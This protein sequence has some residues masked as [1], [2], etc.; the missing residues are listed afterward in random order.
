MKNV[1]Q[2]KKSRNFYFFLLISAI[3][4]FGVIIIFYY[5]HTY[6][7]NDIEFVSNE[8]SS[9]KVIERIQKSVLDIQKMR[10]LAC[11]KSPNE[12]SLHRMESLKKEIVNDMDLLKSATVAMREEIPLR[13][14]LI[15]FISFVNSAQPEKLNFNEYTEIINSFM[16]FSNLV[17]YHCKLILEPD[18]DRY[19]LVNNIVS[20]FPELIEYNGQIRA[21]AVGASGSRITE[22]QKQHIVVQ[23]NKIQERMQKI[24]TNINLLGKTFDDSELMLIY[25][26]M[27]EAQANIE[28]FA[29]NELLSADELSA[30]PNGV[31]AKI[32]QNLDSII[33]LY[34]MTHKVL[35]NSLE[36]KL[37]QNGKYL[38]YVSIFW[39]V[40]VLLV[41]FINR[42]FYRKNREYID[43][44]EELTITDAMTTLYNRRH[45]DEVFDASLKIQQRTNQTLVFII[46]DIDFFKQYNDTYGHQ[47][48]D[49]AIK[50]IAK[51]V[52]ESLR[53]AADMAFRLGG[54]EFGILCI[55]MSQTEAL[56]FANA[57]RE[58]IENKKIEHKNSCV[59]KYLTI[60]MGVIIIEPR[61]I[62]S[63]SEIYRCA[64]QALYKA[65]EGGRNRVVLYD[66][67]Q[68]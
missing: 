50:T 46:F 6:I 23:L 32:T 22:S 7:K 39:F 68:L 41:F 16:L 14:N 48:G 51:G 17:S 28:D 57:I 11:M 30:D 38:L 31:Y 60:S 8:L 43:K 13:E 25:E 20:L 15:G 21:V 47:A 18:L 55:G 34:E 58:N 67:K 59:S 3:P 65:K 2:K 37:N 26:D 44:I 35:K 36:K 1:Y 33:A 52:K 10:G 64:N 9:L 4:F 42:R 66:A 40:S 63:T 12:D 29:K 5:M 27:K 49:E 24:D 54:E 62:N 61:T 56:Y 45:F 19:I 53:R